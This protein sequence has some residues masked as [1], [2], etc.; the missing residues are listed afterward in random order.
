MVGVWACTECNRVH[1][2][3]VKLVCVCV[4]VRRLQENDEKH[5]MSVG[6]VMRRT[7][8]FPLLSAAV[9]EVYQAPFAL[10]AVEFQLLSRP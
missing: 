4:C 9:H 3:D 10:F 6:D 2:K 5:V 1:M 8:A 7:S